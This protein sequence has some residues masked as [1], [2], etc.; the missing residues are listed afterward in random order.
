MKTDMFTGLFKQSLWGKE[1]V[2]LRWPDVWL[3]DKEEGPHSL[4]A[5][6]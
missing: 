2:E 5:E 4:L 3:R 6:D 1:G